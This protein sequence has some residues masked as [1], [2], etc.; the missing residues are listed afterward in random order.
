MYRPLVEVVGSCRRCTKQSVFEW[1]LLGCCSNNK[2]TKYKPWPILEKKP[3]IIPFVQTC[4][5]RKIKMLRS[6]LVFCS[7]ISSPC[8][9][10]KP[11]E[12]LICFWHID[13]DMDLVFFTGFFNAEIHSKSNR[14]IL[15][16]IH[17]HCAKQTKVSQ[18]V[19]LF[20]TST[21]FKL[22]CKCEKCEKYHICTFHTK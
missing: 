16:I 11:W 10:E 17:A 2:K 5:L 18:C 19:I 6:C 8:G 21:Y 7:A 4:L 9:D 22:K 20:Y 14:I 15:M 12:N 13:F 3:N 1:L